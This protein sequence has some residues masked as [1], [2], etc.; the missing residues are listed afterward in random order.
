MILSVLF[1]LGCVGA[2][3]APE[4][5][6]P[7]MSYYRTD[8]VGLYSYNE[9]CMSWDLIGLVNDAVPSGETYMV[10]LDGGSFLILPPE[11]VTA[12]E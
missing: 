9:P 7:S 1:M 2:G 6:A 3:K 8:G 10:R 12:E 11:P 5:P 4:P